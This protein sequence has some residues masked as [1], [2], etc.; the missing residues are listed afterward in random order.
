M[1]KPV[2]FSRFLKKLTQARNLV[3]LGGQ[4]K[5]RKTNMHFFGGQKKIRKKICIFL[6]AKKKCIFGGR[7]WEAKISILHC[8]MHIFRISF[9]KN[10]EFLKAICKKYQFY[11]VKL[12]FLLPRVCLQKCVFFFLPPKKC[13]FFLRGFFLSRKN[14][15][16]NAYFSRPPK[17]CMIVSGFLLLRQ[18]SSNIPRIS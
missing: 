7:P 15:P 12:R 4:E 16:K 17:K 6:V 8:K 18:F 3:A 10:L 9:E 2:I 5:L 14:H 13:I 11:R 1:K